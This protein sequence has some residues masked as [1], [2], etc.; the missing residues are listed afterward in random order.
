MNTIL[1][2]SIHYDTLKNFIYKSF[3]QFK[4]D[5][6]FFMESQEYFKTDDFILPF[7]F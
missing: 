3:F 1:I 6:V 5:V 7:D 4:V 2:V